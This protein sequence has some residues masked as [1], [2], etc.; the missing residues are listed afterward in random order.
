MSHANLPTLMQSMNASH[1]QQMPALVMEQKRALMESSVAT[2]PSQ[3]I[4]FVAGD[5]NEAG[6][7]RSLE[8]PIVLFDGAFHQHAAGCGGTQTVRL[9]TLNDKVATFS[10]EKQCATITA[11]TL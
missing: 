4:D 8:L 3:Y 5:L 1:A 11:T 2:A 6:L 10:C 7:P 9:R